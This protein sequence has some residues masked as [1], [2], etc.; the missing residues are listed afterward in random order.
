GWF[1]PG[2]VFVLDEYCARYGVRG[3]H[4][5]LC[6]LS[7]LLERAE[8]GAMID[9]TLL[10]YSYAFC[11]S[12]VH[13]NSRRRVITVKMDYDPQRVGARPP[14]TVRPP[15]W[16]ADYEGYTVP[17]AP[18]S[19]QPQPRE[20]YVEMTSFTQTPVSLGAVGQTPV[21]PSTSHGFIDI[22][23]QLQEDNRWL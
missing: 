3:C 16:M 17:A 1:S 4:R 14:R 8:N 11:A 23:Q 15:G 21:L 19:D 18:M 20:G 10:H 22:V 2:Q 13:G 7:D 5:H 9:P 6:Y 12:H